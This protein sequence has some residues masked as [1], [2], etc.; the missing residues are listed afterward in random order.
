MKRLVIVALALG[1]MSASGFAQSTT[2]SGELI[3]VSC[4]T[5]KD[6]TA[7]KA[8][9]HDKACLQMPDCEK[10]GY[11][12]YT[13]DSKLVKFDSNGNDLAKK[14]IETT[15]KK[16]NWKVS[17]KGTVNGETIAVESLTLEK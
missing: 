9:E 1:L 17:V 15:D 5:D 8:V 13:S 7:A 14:L 3:D 2:I 11:A 16:D 12:V 6:M 4:G 10:S